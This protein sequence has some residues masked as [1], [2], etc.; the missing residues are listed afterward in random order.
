MS[1]N[2]MPVAVTDEQLSMIYRAAE[3][4]CRRIGWHSWRHSLTGCEASRSSATEAS[5]APFG[6]CSGNFSGRREAN[7][8][9][10]KSTFAIRDRQSGAVRPSEPLSPAG[11]VGGRSRR[12]P[13]STGSRFLK[14]HL[15]IG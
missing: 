1:D 13:K 14:S 11:A 10:L 8:T 3:P 6:N 2:S 15:R 9:R 7:R 4:F 5:P 12:R